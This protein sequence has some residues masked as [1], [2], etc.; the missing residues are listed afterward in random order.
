MRRPPFDSWCTGAIVALGSMLFIPFPLHAQSTVA[1]SG[2]YQTDVA[3]EVPAYYGIQPR[4]RLVYDSGVGDGVVGVGWR[5][6]GPSEVQ[7]VSLGRGAPRFDAT[8]VYL[9]DGQEIV[10][11]EPGM[12]SPSCAHPTS[13][14]GFIAYAFRTDTFQRV[15]FQVGRTGGRWHV[16]DKNGTRY[17]Y[18]PHTY[19][20]PL[21]RLFSPRVTEWR[22]A[23]VEDTSG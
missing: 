8:D 14:P 7:R 16:W 4:L 22:L 2:A 1:P 10:S 19:A 23:S 15:A 12:T 17:I 20:L 3:I 18:A 9:L 13:A 5:L 11:C 6:S 21:G